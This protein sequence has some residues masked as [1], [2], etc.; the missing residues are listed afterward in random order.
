[1]FREPIN[2]T[3]NEPLQD[4]K[5]AKLA[6]EAGLNTITNLVNQI[7]V[8]AITSAESGLG[9]NVKCFWGKGDALE[10]GN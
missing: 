5:K 7:I 4:Q 10:R 1:M 8:T 6:D 9:I 3:K 2:E